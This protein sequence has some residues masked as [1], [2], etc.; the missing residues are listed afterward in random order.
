[1]LIHRAQLPSCTAPS[2]RRVVVYVQNGWMVVLYE[3]VY[4][5]VHECVHEC[6]YECVHECVHECVYECVHLLTV[7]SKLRP[8]SIAS[9]HCG[10][11]PTSG[12][13]TFTI[14]CS[15]PSPSA[16]RMG[17][18]ESG[19]WPDDTT[20]GDTTRGRYSGLPRRTQPIS[21]LPTVL[22]T[23]HLP[24]ESWSASSL[25]KSCRT[26]SEPGLTSLQLFGKR[27]YLTV[28]QKQLSVASGPFRR[29]RTN[30]LICPKDLVLRSGVA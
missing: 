20:R 10:T 5:C 25:R 21:I 22:P 2:S 11:G 8:S 19:S 14:K 29:E 27:P 17:K 26:A 13:Q 12:L 23:W 1:M 28:A 16:T 24:G 4:E 18:W 9:G 7:W 30:S 15:P 6:V 3:C